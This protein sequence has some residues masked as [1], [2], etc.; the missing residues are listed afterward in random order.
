MNKFLFVIALAFFSFS[1]SAFSCGKQSENKVIDKNDPVSFMS[2]VRAPNGEYWKI[3]SKKS[4]LIENGYV[5]KMEHNGDLGILSVLPGGEVVIVYV[6][7]DL[8][9][10]MLMVGKYVYMSHP[11]YKCSG[12]P[13]VTEWVLQLYP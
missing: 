6:P 11:I 12:S 4:F 2:S 5:E 13:T 7:K 1:A 10:T 9:T 3:D 8:P